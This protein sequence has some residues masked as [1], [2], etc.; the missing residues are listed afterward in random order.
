MDQTRAVGWYPRA[1]WNPGT[2]RCRQLP[3]LCL[4]QSWAGFDPWLALIDP[5]AWLF[6][7]CL[8]DLYPDYSNLNPGQNLLP[9]LIDPGYLWNHRKLKL[10]PAA[11]GHQY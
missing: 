4:C 2:R 1:D 8:S 9:R 10:E 5:A 7:N 11:F 6:E 3:N